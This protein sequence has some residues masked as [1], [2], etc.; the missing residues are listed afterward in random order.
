MRQSA[1]R[2]RDVPT[3]CSHPA[4]LIV[5]LSFADHALVL[6]LADGC[7]LTVPYIWLPRLARASA[8]ARANYDIMPDGRLYWPDLDHTFSVAALLSAGRGSARSAPNGVTQS[9]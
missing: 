1:Q 6:H 4:N 2:R 9:L 3:D 5:R 8:A 7:V